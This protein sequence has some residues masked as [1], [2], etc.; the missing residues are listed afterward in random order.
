MT[1]KPSDPVGS[2]G[3]HFGDQ[4]HAEFDRRREAQ[5]SGVERRGGVLG[6]ILA[7][8]LEDSP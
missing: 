7:H 5:A 4:A 6:F 1:E 3:H 2:L 8:L